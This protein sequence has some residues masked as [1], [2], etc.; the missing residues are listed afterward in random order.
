MP[1]GLETGRAGLDAIFF[2]RPSAAITMPSS[3][4]GRPSNLGLSA[5]LQLAKNKSP[6]MCKIRLL[7][8]LIV[9]D[10]LTDVSVCGSA[11][12]R[13]DFVP[14]VS[15]SPLHCFRAMTADRSQTGK[16]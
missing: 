13:C 11:A 6:S 15:P 14:A 8:A 9:A 2:A 12:L 10:T 4:T 5:I 16:I 1:L 7:R 3:H